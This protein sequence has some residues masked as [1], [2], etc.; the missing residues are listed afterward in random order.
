MIIHCTNQ[1]LSSTSYLPENVPDAGGMEIKGAT[2]SI[3]DV[4]W[5]TQTSQANSENRDHLHIASREQGQAE[6]EP[7]ANINLLVL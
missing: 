6:P 1:H 4:H 5:G 3:K 2:V 7:S